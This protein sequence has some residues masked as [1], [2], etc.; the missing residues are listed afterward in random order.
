MAPERGAKISASEAVSSYC[1]SSGVSRPISGARDVLDRALDQPPGATNQVELSALSARDRQGIMSQK[2]GAIDQAQK[3]GVLTAGQASVLKKVVTLKALVD[4]FSVRLASQSEPYDSTIEL[5][6]SL[7]DR[8]GV[9]GKTAPG[10]ASA[11]RDNLNSFYSVTLPALAAAA[12]KSGS[13]E[14][15]VNGSAFTSALIAKG[16]ELVRQYVSP[17]ASVPSA[18]TG[19]KAGA[20]SSERLRFTAMTLGAGALG[21]A[22]NNA[23]LIDTLHMAILGQARNEPHQA[24]P[25]LRVSDFERVRPVGF[26]RLPERRE[27]QRSLEKLSQDEKTRLIKSAAESFQLTE[28]QRFDLGQLQLV[29]AVIQDQMVAVARGSK[30]GQQLRDIA[31]FI[32]EQADLGNSEKAQS[33]MLARFLER[34]IPAFERR[35]LKGEKLQDVTA[36]NAV[37]AF[38][39]GDSLEIISAPQTATLPGATDELLTQQTAKLMRFY[40]SSG[41]YEMVESLG[42]QILAKEI[43][44]AAKRIPP[45]RIKELRVQGEREVDAQLKQ[46]EK[47]VA[48]ALRE[49][50]VTE[51]VRRLKLAEIFEGTKQ[52]GQDGPKRFTPRSAAKTEA[53][54]SCG[55]S[56]FVSERL[57]SPHGLEGAKL[58]AWNEYEACLNPRG[59]LLNVKDSTW[60]TLVREVVINA[61]LIMASGALASGVRTTLTQGAAQLLGEYLV[62]NGVTTGARLTAEQLTFVGARY[63]GRNL[64]LRTAQSVVGGLVEGAVF[65]AA[66]LG[67]QGELTTELPDWGRRVL[68]SAVTLG[69]IRKS[70]EFAEQAFR[71]ISTRDGLT[72]LR[73]GKP[74]AELTRLGAWTE[75]IE[76]DTVRKVAE[77]LLLKGHVEAATMMIAGALQHGLSGDFEKFTGSFGDQLIHAYVTVGALKVGHGIIE[78]SDVTSQRPKRSAAERKPAVEPQAESPSGFAPRVSAMSPAEIQ[79]A[80][81]EL[82]AGSTNHANEGKR[83]SQ[84]DQVLQS[85]LGSAG[86]KGSNLMLLHSQLRAVL[87]EMTPAQIQRVSQGTRLLLMEHFQYTLGSGDPADRRIA[88]SIDRTFSLPESFRRGMDEEIRQKIANRLATDEVLLGI[89]RPAPPDNESRLA[90]ATRVIQIA[91]EEYGMPMPGVMAR[92]WGPNLPGGTARPGFYVI[93]VATINGWDGRAR[94]KELMTAA[95]HEVRHFF[96]SALI[97][98][99]TMSA[100]GDPGGRILSRH[101]IATSAEAVEVGR[102]FGSSTIAYPPSPIREFRDYYR[103]FL[104]RDA[105]EVAGDVVRR[106]TAIR[107]YEPGS[108]DHRKP[109]SSYPW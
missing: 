41:N 99:L 70:G 19:Q 67:L 68:W 81:R 11:L 15:A 94:Y 66:Y 61:P 13:I 24:N 62:V 7:G 80:T 18:S 16:E 96:Q 75:K 107:G 27:V 5:R 34:E 25:K 9:S 43:A 49:V 50:L 76:N 98:Q 73:N 78:A 105:R 20:L 83:I 38:C 109:F 77:A 88:M 100:T 65:D 4:E 8:L 106:M 82:L 21:L 35:V 91:S 17:S 72:I 93:E 89:E 104:E 29:K 79:A 101:P 2:F 30:I 97:G 60:D 59:L 28:H 33:V 6:T 69:M 47:P 44:D 57:F 84:L 54:K 85:L 3:A 87:T 53:Q 92:P 63:I 64:L 1:I 31:G 48:P 26:A 22:G 36:K 23:Q 74:D 46:L 90:Y 40:R 95:I 14:T 12:L 10:A 71:K 56:E 32:T 86:E 39:L 103:N 58:A 42:Q 51:R 102:M 108:Y 52:E 37:L 55:P 45:G